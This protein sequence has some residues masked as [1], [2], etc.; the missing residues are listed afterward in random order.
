[1]FKSDPNDGR[2]R[3][4]PPEEH[5]IQPGEVRNPNG[6]RGNQKAAPI[7]SIEEMY[8]KEARRIVSRD[9]SGD[10]T[11]VERLVQ[12]EYVAGL[13]DKDPKVRARLLN[14]L[15]TLE[16]AVAQSQKEFTEWVLTLKYDMAE[17]FDAAER[18]K[19][20]APD[21]AHPD[22]INIVGDDLVISGPI[23]RKSREDWEQ[24]KAWI[25]LASW[26]HDEARQQYKTEPTEKN[27]D[28]LK[29]MESCRRRLMRKVPKGWNWRE[30]I[31]CRHSHTEDIERVIAAFEKG[32]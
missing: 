27:R 31:Y 6:R 5:K 20:T 8:L 29:D 4:R 3:N 30:S 24:V 16:A 1:M 10:V 9:E 19:I 32:P 2:R 17:R 26:L 7:S 18:R 15:A 23:G 11:A 25:K 13:K 28:W 14:V 22:H 12:E 21:A